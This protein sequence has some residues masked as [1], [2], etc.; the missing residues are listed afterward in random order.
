MLLAQKNF[1]SQIHRNHTVSRIWLHII[2]NTY[3]ICWVPTYVYTHLDQSHIY[4]A[5]DKQNYSACTPCVLL[6][7]TPASCL[8]EPHKVASYLPQMVPGHCARDL[9]SPRQ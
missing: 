3:C 6:H 8:W 2:V 9:S 1:Y 7:T 5:T 4:I